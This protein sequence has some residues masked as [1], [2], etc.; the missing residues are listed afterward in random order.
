[1]I[2][3]GCAQDLLTAYF[4]IPIIHLVIGPTCI[5]TCLVD[6]HLAISVD[7]RLL[8]KEVYFRV[9][10]LRSKLS[11]DVSQLLRVDRSRTV[12]VE[13]LF[14]PQHMHRYSLE[15]GRIILVEKLAASR[16]QHIHRNHHVYVVRTGLVDKLFPAQHIP[17]GFRV[18][19]DRP[20]L[21]K[22]FLPQHSSQQDSRV[23]WCSGGDLRLRINKQRRYSRQLL[24]Q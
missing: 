12:L 21:E 6:V 14:P 16:G 4:R 23:T 13:K 10:E 8:Y 20:G 18:R 2:C 19:A 7:V 3:L 1:M 11:H 15:L 17:Q 24:V 9:G 5:L 22:L